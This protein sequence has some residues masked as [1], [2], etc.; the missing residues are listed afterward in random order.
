MIKKKVLFHPSIWALLATLFL[1][2]STQFAFAEED[3]TITHESG[4]V[5]RQSSGPNDSSSLE[6]RIQELENQLQELESK[7]VLSEPEMIVKQKEIWACDNGHEYNE[8][9]DGVCP[10]DQL[11]LR[12]E[13]TYQREKV[14][15]RQTISE[16]IQKALDDRDARGLD[17][18][19]SATSTL[20]ETFRLSGDDKGVQDLFGVGSTDI[21]FIG[22]PALYTLFFLDIE[23]IGGSSPDLE[24]ENLSMLTSD[25]ARREVDKRANVREAWVR[26]ELLDQKL[27]ISAGVLDIT[28]YF[29]MNAVANDETTQFI[30][31][32]L[33]NNLFLGVPSNGAGIV[34]TLDPKIGFIFRAG[35]QRGASVEQG[36]AQK[37]YSIFELEYLAHIPGLQVGHYRTWVK[38]NE[39]AER[40]SIAWGISADQKI[41]AAVTVFARFGN[42][43]KSTEYNRD[44]YFYS[45]GLELKTPHTFGIRDSFAI[46]FLSVDLASGVKESLAETYYNIFLTENLKTSFH[47]QYLIN[48]NVGEKN[49]SYLIPGVRIQ[50]D[51]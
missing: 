22:K 29:D 49:K 16:Q 21:Y 5:M 7:V 3:S 37:V 35:A 41:T 26:T 12:K 38:F 9:L 23:A 11:P 8:P 4:N 50:F 18:G 51:F 30:T 25:V 28:N 15:R 39:N 2:I 47:I 40:G 44:D 36:L 6:N 10:N 42:Q 13:F 24:I 43:R 27:T 33:V 45:G 31:D 1:L 46:A 19:V 14:F 32:G 48:S 17:I 34:A 20:Q